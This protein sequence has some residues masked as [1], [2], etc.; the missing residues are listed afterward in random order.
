M[1]TAIIFGV[2]GQSGSYLAELLLDKGYRVCGIARRVST[3]NTQRLTKCK[4]HKNFYLRAGDV[5]DPFSVL[6]IIKDHYGFWYE[7][8]PRNNI[9]V[10]N[11]AAQ[12]HVGVSFGEATHSI[13][14]ALNGCL[15]ILEAMRSL[16]VQERFRFYQAS[17]SEQYGSCYCIDSANHHKFQDE[18][19]PMMPNSPYAIAKLAAYHTVRLYREAYGMHASAGILFNHESPRRG[20]NFVTKKI[21]KWV[22]QL[23]VAFWEYGSWQE[24]ARQIGKLQL[25]NIEARR[26]WGFAG[27]YA[28]AMWL[29]L[30]KDKPD[31]YVIATGETHSVL[32]FL[33]EALRYIACCAAI[34]DIC[35]YDNNQFIRPKE[36]E[37][38]RGHAQKAKDNLGWKPNTTFNN[39][40]RLMVKHDLAEAKLSR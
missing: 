26:D 12:S 40:V 15:N 23:S 28:M 10:Y 3:D 30:Q 31:D 29:M 2:T 9:E 17:T 4:D 11:L 35:D 32:E 22:A 5:T 36:V 18:E 38:L 24:A 7:D 21:T 6:S 34:E 27:D 8:S 1:R 14:V 33:Q 25:G 16:G 20:E 19:T 13:Q 39:L 37:Y